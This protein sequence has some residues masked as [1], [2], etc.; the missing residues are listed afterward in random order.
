MYEV[1]LRRWIS[2]FSL[3]LAVCAP[4]VA[5]TKGHQPTPANKP[6]AR[7]AAASQAQVDGMCDDIVDNL[8]DYTDYYWHHGDYPRVI[9]LDRIITEVDPHFLEPYSTGGWLMESDGDNKDAEAYYRL[10]AVRNPDKSYAWF[11]L[12]EFYFNTLHDYD[13]AVTVFQ[14]S[15]KLPDASVND[16]KMLAHSYEK[17]HNLPRALQ[18]WKVI[19]QRYPT[20]PAVDLNLN[21]VQAL[22]NADAAQTPSTPTH[23]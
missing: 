23:S 20:A 22:V 5:A 8:W 15:S 17:A 21:R 13:K 19:K 16:W 7:S 11:Q 1:V 10:G 4:A 14:G 9:H 18:T 3:I 2:A 12:G 6:A